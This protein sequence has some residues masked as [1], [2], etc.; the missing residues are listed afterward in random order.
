M[1][2][3][4]PYPPHIERSKGAFLM[5]WRSTSPSQF[6]TFKDC[7]R[8]WWRISVNNERQPP[9]VSAQRGSRVHGE[10]EEY[11][12]H[13]VEPIDGTA[14]AMLRHLPPAG[15]VDPLYVEAGFS[16][17]PDG[18]PVPIKGR[19]DLIEIE[20]NRITDHKTTSNLK[21]SKTEEDLLRD[22]QALIYSSVAMLGG[23]ENIK[24][25]DPLQFRLVYGTTKSPIKTKVVETTLTLN[26]AK[27][28]LDSFKEIT[29]DQLRTSKI[30]GWSHVEPNYAS[31]DKY[32]GCPFASDCQQAYTPVI[33]I[34][35][36]NEVNMTD[37]NDFLAKLKNRTSKET[38]KEEY[39][40]QY[41]TVNPPEGLPDGEPLPIDED[42]E[43]RRIKKNRI[44]YNDKSISA[45]KKNEALDAINHFYL[46]LSEDQ[47]KIYLSRRKE[48]EVLANL[49]ENL[50]L[51]DDILNHRITDSKK[52]APSDLFSVFNK[53]NETAQKKTTEDQKEFAQDVD[54]YLKDKEP[55]QEQESAQEPKCE[56]VQPLEPTQEPKCE[57]LQEPAQEQEPPPLPLPDCLQPSSP[58]SQFPRLLL[59]DCHMEG[60]RELEPI[61]KDLIKSIEYKT[62]KPIVLM[63]YAK[64]WNIL[65]SEINRLGWDQTIREKVVRIDSQSPIYRHCGWCLSGLADFVIRSTR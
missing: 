60:A 45:L 47:I 2:I 57:P 35:T 51:I 25:K 46:Q 40:E 42:K 7:K 64:G 24:L 29:Q 6:S 18:F 33:T 16:Y 52:E 36:K 30:D 1:H 21:W 26:R 17:T 38:V 34:N 20:E 27:E 43:A 15:S 59:V 3:L 32:G 54:Q 53:R 12:M 58:V 41:E 10:L 22:P 4:K 31:C 50:I 14:Q 61:L 44:R 19:I 28:G 62:Q 56:P 65:A 11:L 23:L 49:K 37:I 8:K 13:S 5:P 48:K 55:V 9:T 63:D 39:K